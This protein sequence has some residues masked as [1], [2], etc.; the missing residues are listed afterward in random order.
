MFVAIDY[1]VIA[2]GQ[3]GDRVKDLQGLLNR[4]YG[5]ILKLDGIFGEKTEAQVKRFQ[6]SC[7]LSKVDGIV[8]PQTWDYLYRITPYAETAHTT[9]R[10]GD[11]GDEVIYLQ[12]RLNGYLGSELITDGLFGESTELAVRHF[13]AAMRITIDGVVGSHTWHYLDQPD[14][15]I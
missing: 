13:Q 14:I 6:R 4:F 15:D 11:K 12:V 9:L 5:E 2:L 10:R 7:N 3:T 8:G 1:A